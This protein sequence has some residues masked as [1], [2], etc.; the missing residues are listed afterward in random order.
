MGHLDK[1]KC[2]NH[3]PGTGRCL[4]RAVQRIIITEPTY[5]LKFRCEECAVD[6]AEA[7]HRGWIVSPVEDVPWPI[8]N[9][10]VC[11]NTLKGVK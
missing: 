5:L 11:K 6:P 9:R 3:I 1:P 10:I 8:S 2:S 7:A 4:K